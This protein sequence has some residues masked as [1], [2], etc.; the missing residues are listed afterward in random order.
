MRKLFTFAIVASLTFAIA[1]PVM[2]GTDLTFSGQVRGRHQLDNRSFVTDHAW[3]HWMELRTRLAVEATVDGNAHA[4]IQLQDSRMAGANNLSGTTNDGMNVDLHQAYI[5]IDNLFGEGWGAAAGRAEFVLGN[6]RVFGAVG[7][8]NVGRSWDG[9][10]FW[11]KNQN[12]SLKTIYLKRLEVNDTSYNADFDIFGLVGKIEDY[13]LEI[14][15][16][17]EQDA[18]ETGL[19]DNRLKRLNGGL[20]YQRTHGQWDFEL[21]GVYQSG[22]LET[23]TIDDVVVPPDT[24]FIN[25]DLSGIMATFE[26]GYTFP[27]GANA[28]FALGIDYESGDDHL[29]ATDNGAYQGPYSTAHKF[30]GHM[31][32]FTPAARSGE[33]YE[34]AGL[35]DY[36]ARGRF[37][38]IPGWTVKGDFHYFMTAADY[39]DPFMDD[40]S[41]SQDVGLELDLSV[42]TTRVAGAKFVAGVS[43]FQAK[44][45][46]SG[47]DDNDM[48]LW[49]Y[50]IGTVNF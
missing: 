29:D 14:F 5:K 12:L 28:R 22:S 34:F 40:G 13:N 9:M 11:Y 27:G 50:L 20:Y 35:F 2:A 39:R 23:N 44:E 31:D 24:T 33:A 8:S 42:T 45:A 36:M 32:Y 3:Q 41:T 48:G 19:Q 16:F 18:D 21:N 47:T 25:T 26:A 15:A 43:G 17:F 10:A 46:F 30:Q 1:C 38:V 6:Q 4:F 49:G 7:W 37:D